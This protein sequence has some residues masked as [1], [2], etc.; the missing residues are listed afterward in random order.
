MKT[1]E[2]RESGSRLSGYLVLFLFL[3]ISVGCAK[4]D[5]IKISTDEEALRSR[6]QEYW[7]HII[8]EAYDKSYDFEYPLY[9][10]AV[11]RIDY[12]RGVSANKKW[13]K[14]DI[15]KVAIEGDSATVTVWLDMKVEN[16][17]VPGRAKQQEFTVRDNEVE[18]KWLKIDGIWYHV[19]KKL[20]TSG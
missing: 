15:R 7:G 2:R 17:M 3:I 13:L 14:A 1:M 12:I 16:L 10:K 5:A 9:Q 20:K 6:V 4:K 19:P 18:E 11:S 8:K